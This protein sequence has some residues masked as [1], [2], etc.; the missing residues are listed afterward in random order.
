[1]TTLPLVDRSRPTVTGGRTL[2]PVRALATMV[3]YPQRPGRWPL[4]VFA[5][6]Y[7]VGPTPYTSMLAAWAAHG[8]V[9]AAP[10]FP[11]TDAAVAGPDIDESDINNQPADVRFVTDVLCG[12]GSPLAG[13]IDST[14]VGVAGHSDGAETALA[15]STDPVPAGEPAFRA[16]M[17]LSGQ[18]VAGAA[19][20]NPPAL[21]VQGTQDVINPP[22]LGYATWDQ[23]RPPKYLLVVAGGTHLGPFQNGSP[24]L[25]GVEA[26]QDAF[27]DAYLAGDHP[28]AAINRSVE[29]FPGLRLQAG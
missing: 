23:G 1:M 13:R 19:G 11:L 10:E 2:S 12:S 20:R 4:I 15:A 18:P 26:V 9:V 25:G 6:G 22:S 28:V 8:Y 29:A 7:Q 17:I 3:W 21:V 14:R 27:L 5:H 16:V 24:E